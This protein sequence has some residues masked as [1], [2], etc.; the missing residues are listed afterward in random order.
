VVKGAPRTAKNHQ[1]IVT[2]KKTGKP[3]VIASAPASRWGRKAI[4]QIVSQWPVRMCAM[5][6]P[7]SVRALIY[8]D[9][10]VGDLDNYLHAVGDALQKAGVILN[11]RQIES[12]DGSRKLIDKTNPRV[13]IELTPMDAP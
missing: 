2:N 8:R 6:G 1:R 7:L 10:R 5:A 9:R 4:G 11:D 13:E 3:F 12:W